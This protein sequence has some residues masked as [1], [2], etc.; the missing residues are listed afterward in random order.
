MVLCNCVKQDKKNVTLIVFG[1]G[2]V[3][4]GRE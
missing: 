1:E 3:V 2:G 4:G